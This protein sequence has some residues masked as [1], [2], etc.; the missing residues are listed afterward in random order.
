MGVNRWNRN[1]L[2]I[3]HSII[4]ARYIFRQMVPFPF[5][6]AI[7]SLDKSRTI[8]NN[9]FDRAIQNGVTQ[10]PSVISEITKW[11]KTLPFWEQVALD[12][13]NDDMGGKISTA[14]SLLWKRY[15]NSLTNAESLLLDKLTDIES[16]LM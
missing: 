14:T 5:P 4:S 13:T 1:I 16:N 2:T 10:M 6:I 8:C 11:A 9:F 3:N 12:N 7:N 15:V